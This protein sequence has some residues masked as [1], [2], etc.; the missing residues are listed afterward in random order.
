MNPRSNNLTLKGRYPFFYIYK[1]EQVSPSGK[2]KSKFNLY[3]DFVGEW[4]ISCYV[5]VLADEVEVMFEPK[6]GRVGL[7]LADEWIGW[8]EELATDGKLCDRR[9]GWIREASDHELRWSTEDIYL[10]AKRMHSLLASQG[11]V[12]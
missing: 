8:A 5:L 2:R 11:R 4:A 10:W 7:F 1:C 6:R 3:P 12:C 9:L